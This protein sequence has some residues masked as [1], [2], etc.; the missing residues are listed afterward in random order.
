MTRPA[1][2]VRWL[3]V[4]G[5]EFGFDGHVLLVDPYLTRIPFRRLWVGRVSPAHELLA[6]HFGHVD[7]ILITHAHF[8][9][10]MDVPE[11]AMRSN[12]RVAASRNGCRL[13]LAAGLPGAQIH[14]LNAGDRLAL[15][16]FHVEVHTA[17]H[18][19]A[20]GFT[21]GDLPAH[22]HAP[23]RARDYRMD[24]DFSFLIHVAGMRILTDPGERWQD[25]VPAEVLFISAARP[26]AYYEQV[27]QRV[28]PR[29]VLPLHWDNLFRPLDAPLRPYY[30]LPHRTW[31]PIQHIHLPSFAQTVTDIWPAAQVM[32]PEPLKPFN[33]PEAVPA[34]RPDE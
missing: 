24:V 22:L 7:D 18:G 29:L 33:M 15:G 20:P 11:I 31:P 19:R 2:M 9:H 27:L 5:L 10:L 4:A 30:G 14:E 6:Q 26:R 25:A 32:V 28:Q 21:A 12:A 8:D 13:L 17:Q 1:L 34:A 23:V 3:G 16:P